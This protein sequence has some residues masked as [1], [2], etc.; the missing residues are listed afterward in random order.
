MSMSAQPSMP[1]DVVST[2][3]RP[4]KRRSVHATTS[5]G[6]NSS[7][8]AAAAAGLVAMLLY[9]PGT[10]NEKARRTLPAGFTPC[11]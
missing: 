4:A 3:F 6:L 7:S 1:N 11:A 9:L 10:Q 5:S 8:I 2:T